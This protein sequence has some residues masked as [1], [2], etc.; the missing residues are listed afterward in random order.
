M[1]SLWVDELYKHSMTKFFFFFFFLCFFFLFF[2]GGRL[3]FHTRLQYNRCWLPL[4][5]AQVKFVLPLVLIGVDVI[6]K[7]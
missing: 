3:L 2:W 1:I 5:S 7:G 4:T 6:I